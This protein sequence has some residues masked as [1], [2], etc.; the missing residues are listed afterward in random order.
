MSVISPNNLIPKEYLKS[1]SATVTTSTF[2]RS[3]GKWVKTTSTVSFQGAILPLSA[4]DLN[5]LKVTEGGLF[6]VNDR[7]L[8]TNQIFE[9]NTQITDGS[10]T[11][12][13]YAPKNYDII[14][15]DFSLYYMKKIDEVSG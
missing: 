3:I 8:Y 9:N 15:P 4:K 14:N 2:D 12:K 7:K 5:Q 11:Y 6:S 10:S 13:V 1:L